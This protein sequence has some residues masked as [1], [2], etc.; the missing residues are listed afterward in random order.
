[1]ARSRRTI[2][3]V[4]HRNPCR[5][6]SQNNVLLGA[7]EAHS[8]IPYMLRRLL[9]QP[10][11]TASRILLSVLLLTAGMAFG[12]E[13]KR[14]TLQG[15]LAMADN[16]NLDLAAARERRAF[17]AA[18]IE[19]AR[20]RPNPVLT[21][22]ASRDAPHEGA[23][24]DQPLELGPKR[25]RRI[26]VA[27]GESVLTE[28]EIAALSRQVRHRVRDAYHAA[29]YAKSVSGQKSS[30]LALA[31]RLQEIAQARFNAGD[32]PELEVI[33]TEV[34]LARADAEV[35]L[36]KQEEA[37]AV[38]RL[39]AL[40]NEPAKRQWEFS[41]SLEMLPA[42]PARVE[43][44]DKAMQ[45]NADL[46]RTKQEQAIEQAR[47]KLLRAER[48]PEF[49][50]GVG[51]DFNNRNAADPNASG[52][53]TAALRGQFTMGLPL[54][55][56]YQGEIAQ[57]VAAQKQL[58]REM[59]ATRRT[60]EAEVESAALEFE[61]RT[62]QAGIFRRTVAPAAQRLASMAEESYKAGKANIL[63]VIDAQRN[64]N[65]VQQEYLDSVLA[66]QQSFAELEEVV[67]ASLD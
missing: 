45:V 31:K 66:A 57:S 20:Q 63:T 59:D 32:V 30:L 67:G 33:Q 6:V 55:S 25:Q 26:E 38:S 48:I 44:S 47:E 46:Q 43:L 1:M 21:F 19:I 51:G 39:N 5:R 16:Q 37:V 40:L 17:A 24:V 58:T 14:L 41:D 29:Q 15:A 35:K 18:G 54:F 56:R 2:Q 61:A 28:L 12:Q 60:I 11:N 53:Y 23:L 27:R 65:Q 50:V 3:K 7:V 10:M 52:S 22:S 13:A 9:D 62:A 34:E 36:A 49:S 8:L 42:A 4:L 64:A